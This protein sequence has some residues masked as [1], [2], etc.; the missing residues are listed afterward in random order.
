VGLLLLDRAAEF[1]DEGENLSELGLELRVLGEQSG[2]LLAEV[3]LPQEVYLV[4][5]AV[6]V[7]FANFAKQLV[8]CY[9]KLDEF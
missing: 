8:D 2:G 3:D 4:I 5:A 9:R 6:V 7:E 1:A